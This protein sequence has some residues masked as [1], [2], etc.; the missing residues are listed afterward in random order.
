[1]KRLW[2]NFFLPIVLLKPML[3]QLPIMIHVFYGVYI[4]VEEL[5][6]VE[7]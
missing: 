1:M 7:T 5:L 6:L 2:I 4:L 3:N